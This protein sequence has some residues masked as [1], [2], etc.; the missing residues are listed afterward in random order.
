MSVVTPG[1][2]IGH[3]L[4]LGV[5]GRRAGCR[6]RCGIVR[7][8]SIDALIA[9]DSTSCG[10]MPPS[11]QQSAVMRRDGAERERR[12]DRDW[13]PGDRNDW[14]HQKENDHDERR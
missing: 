13:R 7:E 1:T 9:G 6:C 3:W 4:V 11:A 2:T 12:R 14:H 5:N 10:C 8:I